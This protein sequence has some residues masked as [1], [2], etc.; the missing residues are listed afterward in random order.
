MPD[1][2]PPPAGATPG[3]PEGKGTEAPAGP[4]EDE[5]TW[6][7]ASHVGSFLAAYVFLGLLCPLIVL[8]TKGR[9]SAFVREHA[10]ESLNFQITAALAGVICTILFVVIVGFFLLAVVG[11]TYVVLVLMA[12]V[13]AS[14]GRIYRYPLSIRF[15]R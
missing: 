9:E 5:R 8:L 11:V 14:R 12:T 1:T 4:T 2:G 13:A 6:A 10:V 7:L 3:E 15:V